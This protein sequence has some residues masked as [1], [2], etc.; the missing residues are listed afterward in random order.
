MLDYET[1]RQIELFLFEEA[2]LL[3]AGKFAEWLK[4]YR[5]QGIY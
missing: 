4:L 2:R 5:P 3:D 1:E